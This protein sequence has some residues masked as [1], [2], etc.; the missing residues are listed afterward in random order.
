MM[1]SALRFGIT[2]L[3]LIVTAVPLILKRVPPNR[4]Y[5]LR[6]PPTGR[7]ETVWYEA[8]RRSGWDLLV[9]GALILSAAASVSSQPAEFQHMAL[10]LPTAIGL[11][12]ALIKG[13]V[14]AYRLERQELNGRADR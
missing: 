11:V 14:V 3:L 7:S 5:G 4:F 13:T 6:V 1:T 12:G 9:L 2:G 10:R 8:N